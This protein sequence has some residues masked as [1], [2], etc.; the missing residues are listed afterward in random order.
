MLRRV[1]SKLAGK[2]GPLGVFAE[3]PV[4][5]QLGIICTCAEMAWA[6]L[7]FTMQF[8]FMDEI[9][10]LETPQFV[11]SKVAFALVAFTGAETLF[12]Y[13]MG[14]LADRF[15]VR[16]FVLLALSVC[17]ITPIAATYATLWW[18]F[19]PL[20]ILDGFAAAALWPCMSALMARS[21]PR[22]AKAAAMSVFNA[23]YMFGLAVGP[24]CGLLIASWRHTNRDVFPFC[25]LI[26]FTGLAVAW[27]YIPH[28][29]PSS[30][31][32]G[33]S[34]K[35]ERGLLKGRPMLV[36]MMFL[37][38]LSQ[39]G[40]GILGPTVLGYV[41]LQFGL[42]EHDLPKL[43]VIPALAVVGIAL[44]LGRVADYIGRAKAV[45]ISYVLATVGIVMIASSSRFRP[46]EGM[47]SLPLVIFG[48]GVLLMVA[49]YILGT[50]AW[51]GITSLLVDDKRQA[52]ALSLMQT[53]QG[54]GVVVALAT[55]ASAGHLMANA[56]RWGD[57]LGDRI[58]I[59][60]VHHHL[61]H[62]PKEV[63]LS[64]WL[65][66]SAGVFAPVLIGTL[67]WVR[68]PE[69][70]AGPAA[71]SEGDDD[72]DSASVPGLETFPGNGTHGVNLPDSSRTSA[73]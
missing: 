63:P 59:H 39:V 50:P 42:V 47:I 61:R 67:L 64:I 54:C 43:M 13:P 70:A 46:T 34:L 21:V 26:M 25:S 51:L 45:W 57:K 58:R 35:E 52:Q 32:H 3:Y 16:R 17:C 71:E 55:V 30:E 48:L 40:V 73:S 12:K 24:M 69:H 49:S 44:P 20:R 60:G 10:P 38:A 23:A 41:K 37:Y 68:E 5:L 29:V 36:R 53:A 9:L 65:W 66:I 62:L 1:A 19:I 15:G 56:N 7:L 33:E 72:G 6:T 14:S 22:E 8:Y 18:E 11:A 28:H 31:V 2:H 27:R 4:L